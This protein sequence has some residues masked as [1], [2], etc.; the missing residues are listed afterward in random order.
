MAIRARRPCAGASRVST[1]PS[2]RMVSNNDDLPG[3]A[4]SAGRIRSARRLPCPIAISRLLRLLRVPRR[5][6]SWSVRTGGGASTGTRRRCSMLSRRRA[7][8]ISTSGITPCGACLKPTDGCAA[9]TRSARA[10]CCGRPRK[11]RRAASGQQGRATAIEMTCAGRPVVA[12]R[13]CECCLAGCAGDS[14]L[15]EVE[16]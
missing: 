8:Q 1:G 7:L 14:E 13:L 5:R 4:E 6:S 9:G 16:A 11:S 12:H 2:K 3:R 10:N 15:W